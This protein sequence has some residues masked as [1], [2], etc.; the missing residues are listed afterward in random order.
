MASEEADRGPGRHTLTVPTGGGKTLAALALLRLAD[1]YVARMTPRASRPA[2]L[3]PQAARTQRAPI[4][5]RA[6]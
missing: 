6:K 1:V 4:I 3:S 2:L 5:R